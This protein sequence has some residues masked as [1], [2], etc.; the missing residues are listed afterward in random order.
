MAKSV[1]AHRFGDPC[2]SNGLVD[3]LL[4]LIQNHPGFKS[5]EAIKPLVETLSLQTFTYP[6]NFII[7][8]SLRTVIEETN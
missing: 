1:T 6:D 3:R 8:E 2:A 4:N 7:P 5:D